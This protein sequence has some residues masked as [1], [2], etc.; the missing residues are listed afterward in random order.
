WSPLGWGRLTGKV[1]RHQ[2]AP[3]GSRLDTVAHW[4]L[5][6]NE[7]KLYNVVDLLQEIAGETGRSIPQIAL[8]WLLTRPTVAT[9]ILGARNESQLQDNLGAVGWSLSDDQL[10]RLDKASAVTPPYPY[11][12]YWSDR[13]YRR[14]NPPPV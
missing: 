9:V 1:S 11:Y 2:S 3:A 7:E 13:S 5:P 8:A 14:L 6:V 4:G 12:A 10:Q